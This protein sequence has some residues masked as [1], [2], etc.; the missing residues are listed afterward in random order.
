MQFL[1][2]E[3]ILAEG[4]DLPMKRAVAFCQSIA[5][6]NEIA[7]SF[8]L[9]SENYL[10]AL[11]EDH[12]QRTVTDGQKGEDAERQ[13]GRSIPAWQRRIRREE[14]AADGRAKHGS[15][16]PGDR[17]GRDGL[18]QQFRGHD[19][20]RDRADSRTNEHPGSA[21]TGGHGEEQR[22]GHEVPSIRRSEDQADQQVYGGSDCAEMTP[23]HAVRQDPSHGC[24][25]EEGDELNKTKYAEQEGR[26]GLAHAMDLT[27]QLVDLG[28]H[29]HDHRRSCSG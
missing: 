9:A 4:D 2:N 1:G 11:P 18:R 7:S 26:F 20:G 22:Q 15:R 8:N 28:P 19:V 5:N 3:A 6:S 13:Q 29:D 14:E 23:I 12:R 10:S 27:G 16:L 25:Q 24:Q 21:I 17:T